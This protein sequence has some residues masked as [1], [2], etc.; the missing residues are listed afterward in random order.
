MCNELKQMK[1]PFFRFLVFELWSFN[2]DHLTKINVFPKDAQCS[3]MHL[4]MRFFQRFLVFGTWSQ[5][6]AFF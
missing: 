5:N 6:G 4:C 2:P 1:N 3:E